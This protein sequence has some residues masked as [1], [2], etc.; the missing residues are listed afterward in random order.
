MHDLQVHLPT[1]RFIFHV[2]C[3][4]VTRTSVCFYALREWYS[5]GDAKTDQFDVIE[6]RY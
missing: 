1:V 5:D 2:F 3:T 4:L 6:P